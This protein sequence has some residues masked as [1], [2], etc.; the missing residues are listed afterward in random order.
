MIYS[1]RMVSND[2][3]HTYKSAQVLVVDIFVELFWVTGKSFSS[4][5]DGVVLMVVVTVVI[6]VVLL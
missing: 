6:L 5:L 4:K 1:T 3:N 2:S